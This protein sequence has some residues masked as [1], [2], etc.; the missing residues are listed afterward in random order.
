HSGIAILNGDDAFEPFVREVAQTA[1][2]D[3]KVVL[4][5]LGS[6]NDIR[7]T[8]ISYDE[9]GRASFDLWLRDGR[10]RRAFLALAGEHNILN[11]L[12]ASACGVA[13]GIDPDDILRALSQA[14]AT[15]MRQETVQAANGVTVINDTYNANPDSMRA[16]LSM[17]AQMN[18]VDSINKH[19]RLH[20]AVL[21]DM[22]ELGVEEVIFHREVGA[23][24]HLNGLDILVTVG[25][26]GAEI[27]KGALDAGMEKNSV[28][29]FSDIAGAITLLENYL[30]EQPVILV[31]ASR[32]MHL[33]TLVE[34]VLSRC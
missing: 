34:G 25:K 11:A 6:H 7:A 18:C 29:A 26:L 31:K 32:G 30:N 19:E 10:P 13:C 9:Q 22:Y 8:N 27:A 15:S 1:E 24:A 5:G 2:R 3:I 23:F 12:A 21:G 20:I 14:Q 17:L 33:E 4:Y 28:H 16:A